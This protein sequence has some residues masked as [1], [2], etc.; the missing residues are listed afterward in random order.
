MNYVKHFK[1]NG[2]DS[3]QVACIELQGRPNAATEGAVGVLGMDM[4][5]PTHEVYKCVAVNGSIYTWELLSAGMS[6]IS[7]TI[8]GEGGES[9]SFPYS[10]LLA[11]TNYL[12]KVGDLILDS[13]GYLY[14]V[15]AIGSDSC[16]ATFCGTHLNSTSGGKDYTLSVDE[17]GKLV[18]ATLSG[19]VV[20][21]V[22]ANIPDNETI[23]R[24]ESTG[25]VSVSGVKS[26]DNST[27]RFYV[28]TQSECLAKKDSSGIFPI[29][30]DGESALRA[31]GATYLRTEAITSQISEDMYYANVKL[32]MKCAYLMIYGTYSALI[33]IDRSHNNLV[34]YSAPRFDANDELTSVEDYYIYYDW[35]NERFARYMWNNGSFVKMM[36]SEAPKF[37]K[38]A[39]LDT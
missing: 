35:Q 32:D 2:V 36:F 17:N 8:T 39:E 19:A 33:W 24:D 37:I 29:V 23:I 16:N 10:T 22:D 12:I 38:I 9:K 4:T 27:V 26:I 3:R 31:L 5:S 34:K 14:R 6:I 1:I 18:L 30:D 13:E 25:K 20:S 15:S 21:E 11:P 28:G 7:A